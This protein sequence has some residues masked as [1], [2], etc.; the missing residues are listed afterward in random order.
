VSGRK[1][2]LLN[3]PGFRGNNA[4][5]DV[6]SALRDHFLILIAQQSGHSQCCIKH[7]R[8]TTEQRSL[9][10]AELAKSLRRPSQHEPSFSEI[11]GSDRQR[12]DRT[13][14]VPS[15]HACALQVAYPLS[16]KFLNMGKEWQ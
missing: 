5:A 3:R 7:L 14:L 13:E 1:G 10:R 6:P 4:K 15:D 2:T 11:V 16:H 9:A 12:F 8:P